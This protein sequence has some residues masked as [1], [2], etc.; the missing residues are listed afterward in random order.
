MMALLNLLLIK[1]YYNFSGIFDLREFEFTATLHFRLILCYS[2][3][4]LACGAYSGYISSNNLHQ[5]GFLWLES[6]FD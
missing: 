2:S 4:L 3:L 6:D 1:T 5:Q